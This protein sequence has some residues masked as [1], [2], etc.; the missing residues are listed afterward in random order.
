MILYVFSFPFFSF[1]LCRGI[2]QHTS[3]NVFT[4]MRQMCACDDGKK[5]KNIQFSMNECKKEECWQFFGDIHETE[6]GGGR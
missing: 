5:L 1:S 2:Q 4:Y 6:R 3:I